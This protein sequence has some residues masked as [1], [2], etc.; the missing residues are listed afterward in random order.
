MSNLLS[1]LSNIF[2]DKPSTPVPFGY[3]MGWIVVRSTDP[4]A[5]AA[6]LPARSRKVANWSTGI[7]ATYRGGAAFVSPPIGGWICI[8][9]EISMG[10]G[11]AKSVRGIAELVTNLSTRFGEAQ[12]F[13]TNRIVEYHHWILARQGKLLRC[14]AHLG[15]I[16]EVI[17]N[18]GEVTEAEAALR[19]ASQPAEEWF[20]TEDDVM[21]VASQ[22]S[23]DPTSLNANSAPA[24]TGILLRI[25]S[26]ENASAYRV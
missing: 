8:V 4:D 19:F 18:L 23:F 7:D 1:K 14:F 15:E 2:Q 6:E 11:E 25:D 16:G 3:K 20:A 24:A 10:V 22:W 21:S 26:H 5:V 17:S 12:G 9:G 13:A